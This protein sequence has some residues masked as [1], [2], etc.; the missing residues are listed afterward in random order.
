MLN[1]TKKEHCAERGGENPLRKNLQQWW[2]VSK[3]VT[4]TGTRDV[5]VVQTKSG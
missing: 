3:N 2:G 5:G 1:V 4:Q